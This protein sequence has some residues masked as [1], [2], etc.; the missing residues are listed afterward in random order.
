M[1]RRDGNSPD[2]G[3]GGMMKN[4]RKFCDEDK[5]VKQCKRV[6]ME[7]ERECL[8]ALNTLASDVSCVKDSCEKI[9]E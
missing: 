7:L 8:H 9:M 1:S 2:C 6:R 3:D 4:A 5:R